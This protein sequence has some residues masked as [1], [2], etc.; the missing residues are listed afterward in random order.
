M[1]PTEVLD[2]IGKMSL[3]EKRALLERLR[4]EINDEDIQHL[5]GD[6]LSFAESLREKGLL[7][8]IPGRN[9]DDEI[10]RKFSR[11]NI[12]G[13]PLSKTIIKDRG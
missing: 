4:L 10:R 13:E 2:E 9:P 6:E 7:S 11:I 3:S 8:E 5:E 12:N 1:T